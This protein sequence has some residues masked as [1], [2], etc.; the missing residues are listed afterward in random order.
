MSAYLTSVHCYAAIW[1]NE[2]HKIQLA[3]SF[4]GRETERLEE[5]SDVTVYRDAT[6]RSFVTLPFFERE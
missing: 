2:G 3:I 5:G 1:V 4:A 6:H